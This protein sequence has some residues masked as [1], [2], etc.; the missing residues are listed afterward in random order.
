M[1]LNSDLYGGLVMLVFAAMFWFHIG[2]FTKFGLMF[3]KVIIVLLAVTGIALIVKSKIK[4]QYVESFIKEINKYMAATMLW[5]LIWVVSANYVGFFVASTI[6]MW[7]IQWTLSDERNL[8]TT[9]LSLAVAIGSV[10]VIYYVF[11]Q[12]LYIFFPQGFLF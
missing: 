5:S 8:K 4:P 6:S 3:P 1:M 9:I 11:T 12:Y 7:A 2:D 10:F